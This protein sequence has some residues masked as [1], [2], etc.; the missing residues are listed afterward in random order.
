[1]A[2]KI[3]YLL[4]TLLL[5][6]GCASTS[7]LPKQC[8]VG[9]GE[10]EFRYGSFTQYAKAEGTIVKIAERGTGCFGKA[11]LIN[12]DGVTVTVGEG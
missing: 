5:V 9:V 10:G 12:K 11:I 4:L 3:K 7:A 6:T 2:G 1:M 8:V